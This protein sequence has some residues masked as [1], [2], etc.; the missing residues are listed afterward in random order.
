MHLFYL[1]LLNVDIVVIARLR[2]RGGSGEVERDRLNSQLLNALAC[3]LL[4][5]IAAH[6]V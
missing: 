6:Y 2:R 1:Q 5:L 4:L 3:L